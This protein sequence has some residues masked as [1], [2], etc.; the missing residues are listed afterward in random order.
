MDMFDIFSPPVLT[1]SQVVRHLRGILEQ[2][3][4]L[5]DVWVRGEVSNFSRPASGHLYF[6][7]KDS[8]A[9][10]RC[11][12][13]KA[14]ALRLRFAPRDGMQVE[15][16]G[17]MNVYEVGGQVQ[18]YIDTMRPAGEGALFQEF[19]R[20]KAK[21]EEEGL[22]DLTHKRSIPE[23]PK[24]IGVV[25]SATGAAVQDILNT[26]ARRL[27]LAK[28]ILAP[29]AVQGVDA[30]SGIVAAIQR[31][32]AQIHPDVILVARGGGSIEDLWAFNDEL[33]ARA[34]F[35]SQAP[36]ISGVG[37]ET[38]FTIADFVADLRAPTPTAAAELATPITLLDLQ[39][40]LEAQQR[41]LS[42]LMTDQLDR[43]G[44]ELERSSTQLMRLSPVMQVNNYRQRLD[45]TAE[46]QARAFTALMHAHHLRLESLSSRLVA[47]NPQAVLN[48]GYA[49]ITRAVD[50][51]VVSQV[52]Q[53]APGEG[54]HL[55]VRD[56]LLGAQITETKQERQDA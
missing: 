50:G 44:R 20:L 46:R 29:T 16:H 38:D 39:L 28:V 27:P 56:G 13:W 8:E 31:L 53:V 42:D 18:L 45:E 6:T 34:I 22:F 7:L 41:V 19:L 25:T 4:I 1:I 55:Q 52:G 23:L 5:Q 32:N 33:V 11:V 40:D 24:T 3:P 12:M 30:P 10:L 49:I 26:L 35:N 36:V 51:S 17:S 37:H 15:A 14:Q 21:L 43:L 47:L 9:S 2:D 48:R 54:V